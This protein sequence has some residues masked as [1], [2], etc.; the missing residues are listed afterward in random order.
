MVGIWFLHSKQEVKPRGPSPLIRRQR[1]F[2]QTQ[3]EAISEKQSTKVSR[4]LSF[5]WTG[6][7]AFACLLMFLSVMLRDAGVFMPENK[8]ISNVI[9]EQYLHRLT[10]NN[11]GYIKSGSG[12]VLHGGSV[13]AHKERLGIINVPYRS[14]GYKAPAYTPHAH[15]IVHSDRIEV[16]Y[17]PDMNNPLYDEVGKISGVIDFTLREYERERE[18]MDTWE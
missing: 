13:S 17:R 8:T 15:I 16:R 6:F 12:S 4:D 5:G 3:E 7:F 14:W 10:S 2:E 11:I 1:V 18:V 9:T